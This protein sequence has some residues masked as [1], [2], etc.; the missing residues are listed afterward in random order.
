M[1]YARESNIEKYICKGNKYQNKCNFL[2]MFKI[3][4]D[5]DVGQ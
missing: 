4:T 2:S 1:I 3:Q 5:A